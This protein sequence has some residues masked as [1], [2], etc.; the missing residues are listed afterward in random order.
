M[1][2]YAASLGGIRQIKLLAIWRTTGCDSWV[3]THSERTTQRVSSTVFVCVR[4]CFLMGL[5][6]AEQF[7]LNSLAMVPKNYF[8]WPFQFL[9]PSP[10]CVPHFGSVC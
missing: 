3:N 7:S 6:L 4:L 2:D 1:N 8:F 10:L 5:L 9:S